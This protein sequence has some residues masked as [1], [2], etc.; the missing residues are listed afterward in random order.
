MELNAQSI[1]SLNRFR[2]R[3]ESLG[4]WDGAWIGI[5]GIR[6]KQGWV[7]FVV[8]AI[9]TAPGV[10][11][12]SQRELFDAKTEHV[13]V[14]AIKVDLPKLWEILDEVANESTGSLSSCFGEPVRLPRGA[15]APSLQSYGTTYRQRDRAHLLLTRTASINFYEVFGHDLFERLGPQLK[16]HNPN[17]GGP[18]EVVR[19]MLP[20]HGSSFDNNN[21]TSFFEVSAEIPLGPLNAFFNPAQEGVEVRFAVGRNV[22]LERVRV[23]LAPEPRAVRTGQDF[24]PNNNGDSLELEHVEPCSEPTREVTVDLLFDDVA[25]GSATIPS[26]STRRDSWA[27]LLQ[28]QKDAWEQA[29][30][31]DFH[32]SR[33]LLRRRLRAALP[34]PVAELALLRIADAIMMTEKFPF[35]AVVSAA[36]VAEVLVKERIAKVRK[37]TRKVAWTALR[38]SDTKLPRDPK[39]LKFDHAIRLGSELGLLGDIDAKSLDL[40][41]VARNE[42]HLARDSRSSHEDFSP[43]RASGAILA[44]LNLCLAIRRRVT[45]KRRTQNATTQPP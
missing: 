22:P 38:A 30:T 2:S 26:K 14:R 39:D 19:N 33:A 18:Q 8:R 21:A 15:N 23:A 4:L 28:P 36:S 9:L 24:V 16:A 11:V 25:I 34:R 41:R 3:I 27:S 12:P 35:F 13:C 37:Q 40:L 31:R 6:A 42:I 45:K 17:F 1:E 44:T 43:V 29:L 5:V 7:A 20:I 10:K 32:W